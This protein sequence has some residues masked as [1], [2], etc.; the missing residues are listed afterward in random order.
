[1]KIVEK[2]FFWIVLAGIV[3]VSPIMAASPDDSMHPDWSLINFRPPGFQPR[4]SG[5]DLLSDG[6]LAICIWNGYTLREHRP[7]NGIVYL[8]TNY[9]SGDPIKT[10]WSIFA[11]G[12]LEPM[13]LKVVDDVIY[14]S[15]RDAIVKLADLNQDRKADKL[16]VLA[17]GWNIGGNAT[18]NWFDLNNEIEG[19]EWNWGLAFS[20]GSFWSVLGAVYPASRPQGPDRGSIIKVGLDGKWQSMAGGIRRGN[21]IVAGPEDEIFVTDNQGEWLPADKLIHVKPDHFYGCQQNPG[22]EFTVMSETPPAVWLPHGEVFNSPTGPVYLKSGQYKG[23]MLIGDIQRN[24]VMRVFL[25]KVNGSYQGAVFKFTTGFE[26]A[27]DRMVQGPDGTVFLGGLGENKTNT[28]WAWNNKEWGLQAIA[29]NPGVTKAFEIRA[30]R[31]LNKDK[32]ELEFSEPVGTGAEDSW[33]YEVR[34]WWY[35]PT[36]DYGGPKM[37]ERTLSVTGAAVSS[38]RMR[39]TLSISGMTEKWIV[40]IKVN[41]L[42]SQS[43]RDPWVNQGWYTLN[44]FGPGIDPNSIP[45][46]HIRKSFKQVRGIST[47]ELAG[48]FIKGG[49]IWKQSG[50]L[51]GRKPLQN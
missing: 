41:Q 18:N 45:T 34:S 48:Y 21:G 9:Q 5:I 16:E 37:D 13:G 33:R 2:L 44:A 3:N 22:T 20:H 25:E 30:I 8:V 7:N 47:S 35:K 12:L 4:C 51:L 32:M 19:N 43:G 14:V 24:G 10:K 50:L 23:Q 27:I 1:M 46:V 29:Q 17:T 26:S 11:E 31:S 42:K 28:G 39:V 49:E 38:D 15:T 6:T 36:Q 40:S